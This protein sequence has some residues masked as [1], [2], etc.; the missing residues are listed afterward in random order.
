MLLPNL[1]SVNGTSLPT[2]QARTYGLNSRWEFRSALVTSTGW[3]TGINL[4]HISLTVCLAPSH[5]QRSSPTQKGL[6]RYLKAITLPVLFSSKHLS[7][8]DIM[9]LFYILIHFMVC[10][11]AICL[12][13]VR[14]DIWSRSLTYYTRENR[15]LHI[16]TQK[17]FVASI[18]KHRISCQTQPPYFQ[19][20]WDSEEVL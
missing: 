18:N 12:A 10:L 15:A 1:S 11:F 5:C 16:F 14:A 9:I 4:D 3:C 8:S 6:P 13:E 19:I 7:L 20:T 2:D 17:I